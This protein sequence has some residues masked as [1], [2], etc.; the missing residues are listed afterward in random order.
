[1]EYPDQPTTPVFNSS[2]LK[3]CL[4]E[5]TLHVLHHQP[6]LMMFYLFRSTAMQ[7]QMQTLC[8][9][10]VSD[11]DPSM[12]LRC[13]YT[14]LSSSVAS[15]LTPLAARIGVS[16]TIFP[17][18][19]SSAVPE[20]NKYTYTQNPTSLSPSVSPLYLARPTCHHG[21]STA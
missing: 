11:R 2:R 4:A 16:L 12:P 3:V 10:T 6:L 20:H 13:H 19:F 17:F 14:S 15:H 8:T 21:S 5:A 18:P 7:M 9:V 1:M